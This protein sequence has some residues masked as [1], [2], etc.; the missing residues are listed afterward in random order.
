MDLFELLSCL[1]WSF[2]E[3]FY[4]GFQAPHLISQFFRIYLGSIYD[5]FLNHLEGYSFGLQ[6]KCTVLAFGLIPVLNETAPNGTGLALSMSPFHN[7]TFPVGTVP[8]RIVK[9]FVPISLCN[10]TVPIGTLPVGTVLAFSL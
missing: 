3:K 8:V 9:A 5:F 1:P 7:Q 4:P 10:R 2:K 6:S